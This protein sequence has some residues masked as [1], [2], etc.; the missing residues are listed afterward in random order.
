MGL[1][2]FFLNKLKTEQTFALFYSDYFDE[3]DYGFVT[4]FNDTYLLIEKFDDKFHYDGLSVLLRKN[5]SRIR[6]SGNDVE[7]VS[8][9]IDNSKMQADSIHI[10][11]AST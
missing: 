9:L 5:I 8:K 10:N 4:D 3:S 1:K 11:L 2:T 7:S 6:W